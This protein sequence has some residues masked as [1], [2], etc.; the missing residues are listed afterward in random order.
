MAKYLS[1]SE[2]LRIHSNM[3]LHY[4]GSHGVRDLGL[5]ES[6]LNR[7]RSGFGDYEQYPDIFSKSAVLLHSLLKNHPFLDGNKRTALASCAIFLKRNGYT[8]KMTKVDGLEFVLNIE[9][10][11]LDEKAITEWINNHTHKIT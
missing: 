5:V 2:V 11:T 8:L 4:G 9:N 3:I 7:P 1:L 6:A 10:D